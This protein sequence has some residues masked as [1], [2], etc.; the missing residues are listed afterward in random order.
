MWQSP[1]CHDWLAILDLW[2]LRRDLEWLHATLTIHPFDARAANRLAST[3]PA[4]STKG[5][6]TTARSVAPSSQC[7]RRQPSGTSDPVANGTWGDAR[8]ASRKL[9]SLNRVRDGPWMVAEPL[10]GLRNGVH[11]L[12]RLKASRQCAFGPIQA[13]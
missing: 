7:R 6:G 11:D 5:P 4:R 8:P 9:T 1:V 2:S 13:T 12:D 3:S 10:E